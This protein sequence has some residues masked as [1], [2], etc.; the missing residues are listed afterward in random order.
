MNNIQN[1]VFLDACNG[2]VYQRE[3]EAHIDVLGLDEF[4]PEEA[5]EAWKRANSTGCATPLADMPDDEEEN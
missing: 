2:I 5:D 4:S 3:P 1:K